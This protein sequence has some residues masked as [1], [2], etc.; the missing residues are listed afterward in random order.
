MSEYDSIVTTET[1]DIENIYDTE[2]S[3]IDKT[4]YINVNI[5][6]YIVLY[7]Y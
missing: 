5:L 3:N 2:K 4:I 1:S 6:Y 7:L